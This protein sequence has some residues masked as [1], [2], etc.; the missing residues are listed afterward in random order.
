MLYFDYESE[1]VF[2]ASNSCSSITVIQSDT[3]SLD[4]ISLN[5]S[6]EKSALESRSLFWDWVKSRLTK[7]FSTRMNNKLAPL[8]M[9]NDV[10]HALQVNLYKRVKKK[11]DSKLLWRHMVVAKNLDE[12]KNITGEVLTYNPKNFYWLCVSNLYRPA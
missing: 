1:Q 9:R 4:F 6:K 8:N 10:M 5:K 7:N 3:Q 11:A 2:A 12:I